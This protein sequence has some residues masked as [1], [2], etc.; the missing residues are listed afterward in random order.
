MG[1]H[2]VTLSTPQL[3]FTV[4]ALIETHG[5]YTAAH[6]KMKDDPYIESPYAV[7][8]NEMVDAYE[9]LNPMLPIPRRE[10]LERV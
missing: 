9:M 7:A 8:I 2:T 10:I 4:G 5:R 6:N 1:N 3:V